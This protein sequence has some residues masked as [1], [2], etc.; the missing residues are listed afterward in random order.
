MASA[1]VLINTDA[2]GEEEV[3]EKLREMKE[4]SEVHVVYGVYD[5]VAKVE[6]DSLD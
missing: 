4:V 6:A 1:I 3:F 2:G 5:I